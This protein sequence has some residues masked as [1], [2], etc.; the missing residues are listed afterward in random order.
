MKEVR[1]KALGT[2]ERNDTSWA[3]LD[4]GASP[5]FWKVSLGQILEELCSFARLEG[6]KEG[7]KRNYL[8]CCDDQ[9]DN[10]QEFLTWSSPRFELWAVPEN[11]PHYAACFPRVSPSRIIEQSMPLVMEGSFVSRPVCSFWASKA[12]SHGAVP[13]PCVNCGLFDWLCGCTCLEAWS[14]AMQGKFPVC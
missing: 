5:A 1:S 9:S 4:S 11:I 3:Q 6:R 7:R 13:V 2:W 12:T 10:T 14:Q 8:P